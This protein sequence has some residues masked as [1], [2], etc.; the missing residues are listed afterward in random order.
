M[1]GTYPGVYMYLAS[2]FEVTGGDGTVGTKQ[3]LWLL[4]AS[5][6]GRANLHI[7]TGA[8]LVP[9]GFSN[10]GLCIEFCTYS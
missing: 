8:K 9:W 6:Q 4:E 10:I 3:T 1:V 5:W 7:T 2:K